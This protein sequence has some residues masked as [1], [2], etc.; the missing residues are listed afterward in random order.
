MIEEFIFEVGKDVGLWDK[1]NFGEKALTD[2]ISV[3]LI[4]QFVIV[5][6]VSK[7]A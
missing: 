7:F 1:I 4:K 6:E 3:S 2:K 5:I